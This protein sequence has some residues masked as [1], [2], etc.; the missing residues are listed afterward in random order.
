LYDAISERDAGDAYGD[1]AGNW[2][3]R[4]SADCLHGDGEYL[5]VYDY[6]YGNCDGDVYAGAGNVPADGGGWNSAHR[7]RNDHECAHRDQLHVDWS[8][9]ER[10]LHAEF[11]GWDTGDVD[12]CARARVGFLRMVWDGTDVLGK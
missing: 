1:D 6:G 5:P 4:R 12:V 7:R 11:P 9:D 3:L 10:N 2:G 8:D